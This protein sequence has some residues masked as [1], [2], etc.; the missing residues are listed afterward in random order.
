MK[1]RSTRL[2]LCLIG[3][4]ISVVVAYVTWIQF[5]D[6]EVTIADFQVG[7][8]MGPDLMTRNGEQNF[9]QLHQL[10]DDSITTAEWQSTGSRSMRAHRTIVSVLIN[11]EGCKTFIYDGDGKLV[12]EVGGND[13]SNQMTDNPFDD[14]EN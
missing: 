6:E 13:D 9:G 11:G 7:S 14:A 1:R 5:E 8:G 4:V 10:I 2:W 3:T 12:P